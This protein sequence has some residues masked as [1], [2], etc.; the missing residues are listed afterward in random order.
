MG[1]LNCPTVIS[2]WYKVLANT[3]ID[4]QSKNSEVVVYAA[5]HAQSTDSLRI[6][7]KILNYLW[8]SAA[9]M[10]QWKFSI[11]NFIAW[12]ILTNNFS[13]QYWGVTDDLVYQIYD[14]NKIIKF[15]YNSLKQLS[16]N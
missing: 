8:K 3:S 10:N 6:Q 11:A 13:E 1:L 7:L 15:Y 16:I 5:K 9:K 14:Q 12:H 2:N 4:Y